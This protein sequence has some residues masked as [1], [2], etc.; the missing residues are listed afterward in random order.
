MVYFVVKE[1]N[2]YTRI[3][4]RDGYKSFTIGKK[5]LIGGDH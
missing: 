4:I 3:R 1:K 2:F 5:I